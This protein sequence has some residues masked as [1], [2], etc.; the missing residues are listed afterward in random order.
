MKNIYLLFIIF[1]FATIQTYSQDTLN[2]PAEYTTIQAAIDAANNGDIVL[3][4]EDTYY[5]NINFIG[6]AITVASHFLIDGDKEHI[7][8][9]IIDGNQSGSV[10]IFD[11]GEDTTS[12][13]Y[14]FTITGGTSWGGGGIRCYSSGAKIIFNKITNNIVNAGIATGPGGGIY[15]NSLGQ[16]YYIIIENNII[17]NNSTYGHL[18][19]GGG[20]RMKDM[21]GRIINNII[22]QNYCR[23]LPGGGLS[24]EGCSLQI[25]NNTIIYNIA[26]KTHDFTGRGGGISAGQDDQSI[27]MNNIV[28]GN[29]WE[30][31]IVSNENL[32]VVYC[33]VEGGYTGTGNID[34]YPEFVDTASGDYHLANNSPCIGAGIDSIEITGTW[35]YCPLTDMEGNPRPNPPGTMP[36]M[37][38]YEN[39]LSVPTDVDDDLIQFPKMFSLSQNY[40]NPF[41][42]TT[43]IKYSIPQSSNVVIKVFDVLGNEITTLVNQ[44]KPI[45]THTIEFDATSLPSGIYFYQLQTPNFIQTKKMILLK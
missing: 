34:V 27:I 13:L 11:S 5:E 23:R 31:Q 36:D 22:K 38:A 1:I 30:E 16:F 10:V 6:K 18:S 42:P 28:W 2:V 24:I 12:V 41:N 29:L 37:G 25:F 14:G 21:E 45:G 43:T 8:N 35:Y 9:T 4:A 44:E 3:V 33:N 39:P 26:D 40:P 32:D 15:A 17:S 19:H 7:D 20:I